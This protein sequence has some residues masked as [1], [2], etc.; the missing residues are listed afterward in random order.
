[1][2]KLEIP[3]VLTEETWFYKEHELLLKPYLGWKYVSY[4]TLTSVEDYE[5]G[6]IKHKLLKLPND[7]TIYTTLGTV[8]GTTLETGEKPSDI[9]SDIQFAKDFDI[10]T[11]RNP[12]AEFEKITILELADDLFMVGFCDMVETLEDGSLIITDLKTGAENKKPY[13]NSEKY[14]QLISY[15]YALTKMGYNV[16]RIKVEFVLRTGSHI[17]PPLVVNNKFS[18]FELEYNKERVKYALD[19]IDKSVKKISSLYKTFKKLTK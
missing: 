14:Y 4:S 9:P 6:F 19:R 8:V 1:M 10:N 17:K 12:E 2:S 15:A 3:S 13:Y 18:T 5:E 11:I 7:G 16:S